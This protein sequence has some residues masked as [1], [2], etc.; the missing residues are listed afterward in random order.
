MDRRA[1]K[2][3]HRKH[4][5]MHTQPNI[6]IDT[7]LADELGK[8]FTWVPPLVSESDD[9]EDCLAGPEAVT[10]E[11]LA[12]AFDAVDREKAGMAG[13]VSSVLDPD[14]E[15]DGSEVLEGRVYDWNELEVVN[16]GITLT[17][18]VEDISVLDTAVGGEW[19]VKAVLR[20]EGVTSSL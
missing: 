12:E 13:E 20:S 15:L 5:H 19:D 18:F 10:D 17:G 6:G 8:T 14:I 7:E 1:G 4:A 2:S 16:K 9:T 3:T 11:E